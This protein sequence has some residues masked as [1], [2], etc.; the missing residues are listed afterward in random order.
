[1]QALGLA[2]GRYRLGDR[3]VDVTNQGA[4]I[5]GT[6]TLA[7]SVIALDEAVRRFWKITGCTQVEAL[8]AAS[9]IPAKIL[10]MERNKGSLDIGADADL[11]LLN[12]HLEVED[13]YTASDFQS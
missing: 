3:S 8:E 10:G 2:P 1:M 6:Q 13:C 5:A 4:Y 9:L 11:V 12:E 7:G